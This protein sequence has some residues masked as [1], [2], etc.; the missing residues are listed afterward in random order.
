MSHTSTR[1]HKTISM[2][3]HQQK[4]HSP[5]HLHTN[6]SP[7]FLCLMSVAQQVTDTMCCDNLKYDAEEEQLKPDN[8]YCM[9]SK[10][11]LSQIYNYLLNVLIYGCTLQENVTAFVRD[12]T[13][14]VDLRSQ[15]TWW[16][17][18]CSDSP[19]GLRADPG[20]PPC[21][22]SSQTRPPRKCPRGSA[23]LYE[24]GKAA[25]R[26][27]G[28]KNTTVAFMTQ[29]DGNNMSPRGSRWQWINWHAVIF[30]S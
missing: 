27:S 5:C 20:I 28:P 10:A 21:T 9:R 18:R 2:A 15:W 23:H 11:V 25:Y 17:L 29:T 24:G 7:F 4:I 26:V 12:V 19:W 16:R 6:L 8:V 14:K 3:T 1:G 13:T 22:A 30:T